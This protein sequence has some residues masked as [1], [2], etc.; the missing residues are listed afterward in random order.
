MPTLLSSPFG[1]VSVAGSKGSVHRELQSPEYAEHVEV[2]SSS[3]TPVP[4]NS[5][6][7]SGEPQEGT[8]EALVH[9]ILHHVERAPAVPHDDATLLKVLVATAGRGT[10][11]TAATRGEE[12]SSFAL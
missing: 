1:S 2:P 11:P 4:K 6:M 10:V 9:P 12:A 7:V 3:R 8:L 5:W